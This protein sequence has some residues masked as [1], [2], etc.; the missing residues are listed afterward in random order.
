MTEPRPEPLALRYDHP[1]RR[2]GE[3]VGV[4][5]VTR[6]RTQPQQAEGIA[7][8]HRRALRLVDNSTE[9]VT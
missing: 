3:T 7:P 6:K 5:L 8:R 1:V 2:C 4:L 9:G